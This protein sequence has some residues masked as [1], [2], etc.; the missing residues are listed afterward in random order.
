MQ[1]N[2][3]SSTDLVASLAEEFIAEHS[4][5][6]K[7][8]F[9]YLPFQVRTLLCGP[10]PDALTTAVHKCHCVCTSFLFP[11][12]RTATHSHTH[13]QTH[14]HILQATVVRKCLCF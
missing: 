8:F 10:L 11:L 9:L 1:A 12:P 4:H 13:T 6:D 3:S 7:P 14:T 2:L 5:D